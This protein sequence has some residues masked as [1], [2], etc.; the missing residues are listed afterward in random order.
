MQ[1][2]LV[3]EQAG[4]AIAKLYRDF[5]AKAPPGKSIPVLLWSVRS[6]FDDNRGNRT[7]FAPKFYFYWTNGSEIEEYHYL[8]INVAGIGEIAL[9]PGELFRN[10]SHT[11]EAEGDNLILAD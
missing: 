2:V 7:T 6:H 9:A 4:A 3:T 10:G 11:I 8:K 5:P 1:S